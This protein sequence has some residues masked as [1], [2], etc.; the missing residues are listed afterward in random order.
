MK[1]HKLFVNKEVIGED[2]YNLIKN[3]LFSDDTSE[4]RIIH[5]GKV[6]IIDCNNRFTTRPAVDESILINQRFYE[7]MGDTH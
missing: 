3:D 6:M 4:I 1:I 7:F 2:N 5:N